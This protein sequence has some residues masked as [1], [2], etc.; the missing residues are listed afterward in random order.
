[1]NLSDAREFV[2]P[3]AER[4]PGLRAE[5]ARLA[6]RSLCRDH[7]IAASNWDLFTAR[8]MILENGGDIRG[9]STKAGG[10]ALVMTLPTNSS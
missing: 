1:M 10:I 3:T 4:D 5:I 8:Q 2:F 7:R 6:T 9:T